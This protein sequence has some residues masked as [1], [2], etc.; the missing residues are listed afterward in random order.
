MRAA[1]GFRTSPPRFG[2]AARLVVGTAALLAASLLPPGFSAAAAAPTEPDALCG[3]GPLEILL[4]NDDGFDSAGIRALASGLAA[5]GHRVTLAAPA[6][7]ASGSSMSF[8]WG[9]IPVRQVTVDPPVFAVDATPASVVVLAA[10]ALYPAGRRPDLV[11]SGINHGPNDGAL[12]ML[13]GTVGAAIAGTLLLDP[14]V[15]G[16]AVNAGR[17]NSAEPWDSPAH[18]AQFDAV[19]AHLARLVGAS[20]AWFCNRGRVT[21]PRTVLNVNYPAIPP[22]QWRGTVVAG[23]DT[24]SD[25]HFDF[26]AT[27]GGKYKPSPLRS[28]P[29]AARGS[30][31]DGLARGYVTVTPLGAA[32]VDDGVSTG[33]PARALTRRLRDLQP[34]SDD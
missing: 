1:R 14:P 32:I 8:T 19:A 18:L 7:N 6:R 10:T 2:R 20:R 25:L 12:L 9:E 22:G 26:E 3:S 11:V 28:D 4:T 27:A 33:T 30:D 13:S 29:P 34:R 15:P 5:A 17:L 21:R 16:I 24:E 23:Q 31:R